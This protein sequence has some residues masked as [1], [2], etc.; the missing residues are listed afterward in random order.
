MAFFYGGE[1]NLGLLLVAAFVI[2]LVFFLRKM[3]EKR[4]FPYIFLAIIVWILFYYSGIHATMSG[5]VMAFLIPNKPRY[6]K[7]EYMHKRNH[8]ISLLES[9]DGFGGSTEFPN[10][11]QKVCLVKLKNIAG[12][13]MDMSSRVEKALTPY[14]NFLIM[15]LF[16]LANAG[17]RI[18]DASYFNV[19]AYDSALGGVGMGI[20]LGLL[21]GK[22]LGI[23][24]SSFA[25][26]KLKFGE[27]PAK[28]TWP[29]FFAV[30]CL[31]GI[32]FT[33]SIF[34]DTLSFGDQTPQ[35]VDFLRNAGKIAV[36]MGSV[37]SAVLGTVL[38]NIFSRYGRKIQS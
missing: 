12:R 18:P 30:A 9:Y 23:T 25:A 36:L 2:A 20:F 15:P 6:G 3:G 16:A 28:A 13:S 21:V 14:V 27:M 7:D 33:M 35:T 8:Y 24:L 31:G 29:M 34:V 4:Y 5:V 11:A 1:I 32:G 37:C 26:V 10:E 17:V 38:V 19:F 22:P